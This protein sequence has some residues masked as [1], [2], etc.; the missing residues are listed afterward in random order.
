MEYIRVK[1]WRQ[2]Q[3]YSNR[4]PPWIKLHNSLMEDPEFA[5][6]SDA[7]KFHLIG[8]WLLASRTENRVPADAEFIGSRINAETAVDLQALLAAGF[9]E[10]DDASNLHPNEN[11]KNTDACKLLDQIREEKNRTEKEQKR[12][13]KPAA[14]PPAFSG[15]ILRITVKQ[16]QAFK[17]AFPQVNLETEYRKMDSWLIAHPERHMKR[18]GAFAHNWLSRTEPETK[19][20]PADDQIPI[21]PRPF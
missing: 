2:F 6:L 20:A 7:A 4:V 8:I 9:L 19:R 14:P 1:N 11:N 5:R 12:G 21:A 13:E 15:E 17:Q 18:Q 3:H 10:K 16:D